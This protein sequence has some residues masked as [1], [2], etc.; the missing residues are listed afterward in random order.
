MSGLSVATIILEY[1]YQDV[2][3]EAH[4]SVGSLWLALGDATEATRS[5]LPLEAIPNCAKIVGP[6]GFDDAAA[7][8]RTLKSLLERAG[9]TVVERTVTD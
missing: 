9:V 1:N 5:D 6:I 7:A 4:G 8:C 2:G 3:R